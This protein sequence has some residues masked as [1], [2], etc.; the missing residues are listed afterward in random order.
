MSLNDIS[1][2]VANT[3]NAQEICDLINLANKVMKKGIYSKIA[4]ITI[5]EIKE[6]FNKDNS[7]FLITFE[8]KKIISVILIN[9][10]KNKAYFQLLAVHPSIKRGYGKKVIQLAEKYVYTTL[11]KNYVELN[12]ARKSSRLIKYYECQGYKRTGKLGKISLNSE[13]TN[14]LIVDYLKKKLSKK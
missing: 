8:N 6:I 9:D 4:R 7:Y 11:G 1:Y 12:T 2:E 3:T 13:I 10:L 5:K 14:I